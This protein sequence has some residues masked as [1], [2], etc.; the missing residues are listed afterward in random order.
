[1]CWRK[2]DSSTHDAM[3][4]PTHFELM[5]SHLVRSG[6][7]VLQKEEESALLSRRGSSRCERTLRG[8]WMS[9]VKSDEAK[10]ATS[11]SAVAV[12]AKASRRTQ[13]HIRAEGTR[14]EHFHSAL[15]ILD[16]EEVIALRAREAVSASPNAEGKGGSP[17]AR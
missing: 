5:L 12:S 13:C 17:S 2:N 3:T 16:G 7:T 8:I 6:D 4:V 9:T 1:M 15:T 10:K 14:L 11:A